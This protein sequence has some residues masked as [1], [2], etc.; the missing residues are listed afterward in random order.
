M[1][2]SR[3]IILVF[4]NSLLMF[5]SI[6]F[7]TKFNEWDENFLLMSIL[8]SLSV[9][10]IGS[11]IGPYLKNK[12][13]W[14]LSVLPTFSLLSIIVLEILPGQEEITW[15]FLVGL[16]VAAN[17]LISLFNTKTY[18]SYFRLKGK[19]LILMNFLAAVVA[20]LYETGLMYFIRN[21]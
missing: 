18:Q 4:N 17:C 8:V 11:L 7:I 1:S 21:F 16:F 13:G 20:V 10:T 5:L 9:I 12:W 14:L 3:S 2:I 6:V 19:T 15:Q